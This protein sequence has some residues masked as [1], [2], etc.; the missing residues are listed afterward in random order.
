M[1]IVVAVI[2]YFL[3]AL[4]V[5][6]DKYLLAG[7]LPNP[8]LYAFAIGL[9]GAAALVLVPFGFL[10]FPE[11]PIIA[12]GVAAGFLQ[13]FAILALFI[14]LKKFEAS[15]VIPAIGGFL[16]ILTIVSTSILGRSEFE[17]IGILSF[18]LLVG[19]SILVSVERDALVTV[20]SLVFAFAAA[21]LFSLFVV[22]SKFVYEA[23]PFLS[24]L[25]W[26]AIGGV[27]AAL[28]LWLVSGELRNALADAFGKRGE[29]KKALSPAVFLLFVGNQGFGAAGFVLQNW[30]VALAPF[31]LIAFVNA[32]EGIKYVFVL[33]MTTF[34]SPVFPRIVQERLDAKSI[35]QKLVAISFIG[36]GLALLA[37]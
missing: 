37:L 20:H 32:L 9:F 25:L 17:G 29:A 5:V 36:V 24:G 34:L 18:L 28:F 31:A 33:G 3:L 8:K 23:Q 12:L 16:P 15:R 13:V 21:F 27:F 1:W 6:I 26:I 10:Q 30:A 11:K 4:V 22:S 19:G 14:A 35:T 2:A 7:P